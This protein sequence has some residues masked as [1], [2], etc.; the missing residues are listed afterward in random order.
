MI[1]ME[2]QIDLLAIGDIATEPFIKINEAEIVCNK[3]KEDCKLCLNYKDKVPYEYMEL[4]N[5]VG[6]SPNV[7]ISSAKLG[8]N[9]Y[10]ISYIGDDTIGKNNMEELLKNNV[11]TD[12][13]MIVPGMKSNYHFVLWHDVDRTILVNHTEFPYSFSRDIPEPKWIYLSSLSSNSLDYHLEILSYLNNHPNIKLALQPGTFQIKLGIQALKELYLRT[14]A[15]FC[16]MEEAERI[17]EK[18]EGDIYKILEDL[19]EICKGLIVVT[20]GIKGSYVYDTD[21]NIYFCPIYKGD[22]VERTGA[23]D[24]FSSAFVSALILEKDIKEALAWGAI[25]SMSVVKYIGPHKGL[26]T[27][28]QIEELLS[29]APEDFKIIKIN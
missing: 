18:E 9:S 7:A 2:K 25:N 13:M 4:C 20:D 6:N 27:K 12:Y 29:N 19:R 17:L 10:I 24:A 1:D 8:I 26:L 14:D 22:P 28:D 16:N 5:A 21:G 3:N 15:L 23:G 11:K